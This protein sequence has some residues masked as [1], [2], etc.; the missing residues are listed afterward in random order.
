VTW[1]FKTIFEPLKETF[2]HLPLAFLLLE[3]QRKSKK[4][5]TVVLSMPLHGLHAEHTKSVMDVRNFILLA[6]IGPLL[7]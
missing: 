7:Y 5:Q 1:F 3:E 2:L 6:Y 4:Y